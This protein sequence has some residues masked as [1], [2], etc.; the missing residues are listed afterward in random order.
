MCKKTWTKKDDLK[1]AK[2]LAV[3]NVNELPSRKVMQRVLR[4]VLND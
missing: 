1:L 2:Y 4:R 3:C